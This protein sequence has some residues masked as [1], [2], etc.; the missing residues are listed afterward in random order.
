[1]L[2]WHSWVVYGWVQ[3][4]II[5]WEEFSIDLGHIDVKNKNNNQLPF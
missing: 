3:I 2:V 1:M 5:I 4:Y